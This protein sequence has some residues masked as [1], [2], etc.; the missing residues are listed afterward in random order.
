MTFEQA[1]RKHLDETGESMRALSLRAGLNPKAV[2]D[3]LGRPGLR[4]KRATV[5]ALSRAVGAPLPAP[6]AAA[7]LTY[8]DLIA[9][10]ERERESGCEQAP[11][12][13]LRLRWLLRK[14]GWVAE[15]ELVDRRRGRGLL[16]AQ[17]ARHLR[18]DAGQL[19]HVQERGPGPPAHGRRAA[20][21]QRLG[22]RGRAMARSGRR[23]ATA[24]CRRISRTYRELSS[25]SCMTGASL[26]ARSRRT[27]CKPISKTGSPARASRRR[28]TSS[29]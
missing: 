18:P 22:H 7:P 20:P 13:I 28:C 10:L 16:R 12:R 29:T 19:L 6:Q 9:R 25:S 5:D 2:S 26:R 3:I 24:S 8:A 27:R 14:A 4:P 17:Q 1:L 15:T 11:R 23:S 21:A